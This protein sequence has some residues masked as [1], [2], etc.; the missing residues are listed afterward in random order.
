MHRDLN[1]ALR[2]EASA[3]ATVASRIWEAVRQGLRW[4][5]EPEG[6]RLF[7]ILAFLW[8]IEIFLVQDVTFRP[9]MPR[10]WR[11]PS[12]FWA[13]LGRLSIN[14]GFT[15]AVLSLVPRRLL[16]LPF[17][18]W[19]L[20]AAVAISYQRYFDR[21]L[22]IQT[23]KRSIGE[24]AAVAGMGFDLVGGP[25]LVLFA[26]AFLVKVALAM[27]AKRRVGTAWRVGI[28]GVIAWAGMAG[29][30]NM[31]HPLH[32][33]RRTYNFERTGMAYGYFF[34]WMAEEHFLGGRL[35]E[36][37][38]EVAEQKKSNRLAGEHPLPVSDRVVI[39]QV[40]SL[41]DSIVDH[42]VGG[43][44][45]MPFLAALRASSMHYKVVPFHD[46][47]SA[48][49][50]FSMLTGKAPSPDLITYRLL[51][52]PY[53]QTLPQ[54]FE[55]AGYRSHF[56][57]GLFGDFFD[58]RYAFEN[59][60][61][62]SELLFEEELN[63]QY[64][65]VSGKWGIKDR[66]VFR[67]AADLLLQEEGKVFQFVI[68]LTSHGPFHFLEPEEQEIFKN[69]KEKR[70]KYINHMRYVDR[71]LEEYYERLPEDTLLVIYGDHESATIELP[72]DEK[73]KKIEFVPYFIHHKGHTLRSADPVLARSGELHQLDM[74]TY[75]RN[76][77][78]GLA[79]RAE[80][81]AKLR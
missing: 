40:E 79:P 56:L 78:L 9:G 54:I 35:L 23:A 37:A 20:W 39:L 21:P 15:L 11:G 77:A 8:A 22:G 27:K 61:G 29:I 26:V 74:V 58:R 34:T 31:G 42:K 69:P 44:Y 76:Y 65:L 13:Q 3:P 67:V 17:L 38:I 49:A 53:G 68:T 12:L 5:F 62:F 2:A 70:E 75:I 32:K 59:F 33:M 66:D 47:G 7:Y 10:D 81:H 45:V 25:L 18:L 52:Y 6:R 4:L 48:D 41:E 57:H 63:E 24:G 50:D 72:R 64:G 46:H 51:D 55:E 14:L 30:V 71:V 36:R 80:E 16:F 28:F 43:E 60:M 19:Q 1:E 73:G